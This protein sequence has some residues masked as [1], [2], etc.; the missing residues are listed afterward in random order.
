[1]RKERPQEEI[2]GKG[3]GGGGFYGEFYPDNVN[4]FAINGDDCIG[5]SARQAGEIEEGKN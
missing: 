3:F 4:F 5:V 1:V 2:T